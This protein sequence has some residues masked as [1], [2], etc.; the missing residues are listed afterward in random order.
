MKRF[1]LLLFRLSIFFEICWG[2]H[3]WFTWWANSSN[4]VTYLTLLALVFVALVYSNTF[5]IKLKNSLFVI[6]ALFFYFLANIFSNHFTLQSA[7]RSILSLFPIWVLTSDKLDNIK[8]HLHF[9]VK[10]LSVILFLGIIEYII[11]NF[12]RMPGY[13]IQYGENDNYIFFNYGFY[14]KKIGEYGLISSADARSMRFT[15]V[16]LEPGY[17]SAMLVF[18]IYAR[19]FDFTKRENRILLYSILLSFSLAGYLMLFVAYIFH[20][21]INKLSFKKIL[22]FPFVIFLIYFVAINFNGGNNYLN[23]L[24]VDRLMLDEDLLISGNNRTT[25]IT[26]EYFYQGLK[27]GD[28]FFGLGVEKVNQ[29]N[30]GR[31]STFDG[32]SIAGTGAIYYFVVHGILAALLYLLFYILIARDSRCAPYSTYFVL[33]IM[34]CFIQASYPESYSWIYPFILGLKNC[35]YDSKTQPVYRRNILAVNA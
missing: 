4:L 21:F 22:I 26:R 8:G 19:K 34:I 9:T 3:A 13:L 6:A 11:F 7:A 27:N 17:L 31:L 24:I 25:E 12:Y 14:L 5:H 16:F 10:L 32:K 33:L 18:L 2:A 29:L 30:G 23:T 35:Q 28:S 1:T 20:T 15:G